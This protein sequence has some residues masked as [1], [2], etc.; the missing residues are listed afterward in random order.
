MCH[1]IVYA[2]A[3]GAYRRGGED[4]IDCEGNWCKWG[5]GFYDYDKNYIR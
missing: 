2:D 3:S 5:T 1:D 4:F